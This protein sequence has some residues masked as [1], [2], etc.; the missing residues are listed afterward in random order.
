MDC[1]SFTKM[2]LIKLETESIKIQICI[3]IVSGMVF[4]VFTSH[5]HNLLARLKVRL[6]GFAGCSL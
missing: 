1:I 2:Y 6:S 3:L 4:Q 5:L